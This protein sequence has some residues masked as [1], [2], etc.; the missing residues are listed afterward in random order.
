M[1]IR[2]HW[3]LLVLRT[4]KIYLSRQGGPRL[5]MKR[6]SPDVREIRRSSSMLGQMPLVF[7]YALSRHFEF[8]QGLDEAPSGNKPAD[9]IRRG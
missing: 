4:V 1:G 9:P 5:P 2:N 7:V 3:I 6:R 8:A